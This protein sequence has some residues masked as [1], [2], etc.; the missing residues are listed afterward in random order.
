[1]SL[2]QNKSLVVKYNKEVIETDNMV[3]LQEMVA[4][5]FIN[6]S[7]LEGMSPGI[8]G[9]IYFF[10]DIMHSAFSSLK[11]DVQDMIAED[12]KVTTR[13]VITGIHQKPLFGI[14]ATGKQV[15]IKVIDIL[16]I[17]NNKIKEHW[18]ENNF[19]AV[20]QSLQA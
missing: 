2:A 11:V 15:T 13:K 5:D 20:I 12:N 6:H 7:A 9:L 8:D 1:M 10:T 16:T 14:P 4:T 3:L 17:E 19:A 18:G